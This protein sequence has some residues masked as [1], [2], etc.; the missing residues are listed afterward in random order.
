MQET[1]AVCCELAHYGFNCNVKELCNLLMFI[2]TIL[3]IWTK[4]I[5]NGLSLSKLK[6][7]HCFRFQN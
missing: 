7:D 3:A 4:I 1:H 2:N 5:L 6:T